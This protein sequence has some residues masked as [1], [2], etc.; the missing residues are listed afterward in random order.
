[1]RATLH[2]ELMRE[3]GFETDYHRER[4]R[5]HA[6]SRHTM[7]LGLLVVIVLCALAG[8]VAWLSESAALPVPHVVI[9]GLAAAGLVGQ[10]LWLMIAWFSRPED[11]RDRRAI[12]RAALRTAPLIIIVAAVLQLSAPYLPGIPKSV[13]IAALV[14]GLVIQVVAFVKTRLLPWMEDQI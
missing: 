2:D 12:V 13:V 10:L 9:A 6:V 7:L 5:R 3:A 8:V 14:L 4:A 1:V 11:Q